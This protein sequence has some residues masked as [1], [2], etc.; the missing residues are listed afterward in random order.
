MPNKSV[1]VKKRSLSQEE[2]E[3]TKRQK[4]IEGWDQ[5]IV[6]NSTVFIA[7]VGA[8]GCEIAKDLALAGIGKLILC[9][10]DTIETSNLS[11][12]M[13]F[14]KGD[15]GRYKAEVAA[16]RLKLMNPFM[17]TEVYTIPLQKISMEKYLECQVVIAALDNVQA[18]M[19]LNK[20]CQKL[21]IPLIEGGT[22][23]F[24]GHVQVILPEKTMDKFGEPIPFGNETKKIDSIFQEKLWALEEENHPQYFLGMTE[25]EQLED[26]IAQ[27]KKEKITP[28]LEDLKKEAKV[29]FLEK[30]DELCNF[31]PCYRCVV[32]IPPPLRNQ[33]AACTLKGIPRTREH[34]AIR[35][36]VLFS[37][38]FERKPDYNNKIEMTETLA[39]AQQELEELRAR[40]LDESIPPE[41]KTQISSE[42][43]SQIKKNILH[44]FGNNFELED[45]EN[46]LGNKIPAIQSVSSIISSIQSQEAIKLVFLKAGKNVGPIMDPPYINYNGV[47]G[48]FDQ[49]DISRIDSCV[50]CGSG[51]GQENL[52]VALPKESTVSD[53]FKAMNEVNSSITLDGWMITNPLTKQFVYNPLFE[54]GRTGP[55]KLEEFELKNLDE[56]TL[57]AFGK[58]KEENEIKQFN[59]ILQLL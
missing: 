57:T 51:K 25:I 55:Q 59:V 6:K 30:R 3:R 56:I 22:V 12:Q 49:V 52:T 18:R 53:L 2:R 36:E 44:T 15:E 58:K 48:I 41:Y 23:G 16:E 32:P 9:D 33:V 17:E 31:T 1:E 10:L 47:Y 38:K 45:M 11:R 13:L 46:I 21:K 19:D 50:V 28:V 54:K 29:E 35:G 34:C 4:L 14:Y 24:E 37:K 7:G 42:E 27:I 40:V 8:L 26:K 20:F 43:V 5:N 39:F